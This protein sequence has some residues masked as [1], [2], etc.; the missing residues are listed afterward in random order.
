VDDVDTEGMVYL[1][2]DRWNSEGFQAL[3]HREW[4]AEP[5]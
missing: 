3:L 4:V 5:A 1:D 2:I